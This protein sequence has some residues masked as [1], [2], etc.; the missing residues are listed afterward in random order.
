MDHLT[1]GKWT[2]LIE[3]C[4]EALRQWII[5]LLFVVLHLL[6]AY[7][8]V[9]VWCCFLFPVILGVY[10]STALGGLEQE[11]KYRWR[12]IPEAYVGWI[13]EKRD[14]FLQYLE[15]NGMFHLM[16]QYF[17]V[18]R[19][20]GVVIRSLLCNV[21]MIYVR[22][23]Q[24]VCVIHV[25][26]ISNRKFMLHLFK[27][28][29]NVRIS[30]LNHYLACIFL[31]LLIPFYCKIK[32]MSSTASSYLYIF[33]VINRVLHFTRF[34]QGRKCTSFEMKNSGLL[35]VVFITEIL[36][37]DSCLGTCY[38]CVYRSL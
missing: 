4:K 24:F 14:N 37:S 35:L 33:V 27:Q 2:I 28:M 34:S 26:I 12:M 30:I 17:Y 22:R 6:F 7:L 23:V 19:Y 18:G 36:P 9:S 10:L 16:S 20:C 5:S 15:A 8:P 21:F 3:V 38:N 1:A 25:F 29:Q 32:V 31:F 11:R 13:S